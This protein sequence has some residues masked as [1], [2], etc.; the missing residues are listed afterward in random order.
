MFLLWIN[1]RLLE[2]IVSAVIN[3]DRGK[4]AEEIT[5][6]PLIFERL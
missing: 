2:M 3:I 1:Y 4:T 5:F 6:F